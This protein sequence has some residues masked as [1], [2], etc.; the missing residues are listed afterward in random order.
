MS[1][2]RR[3]RDAEYK[4]CEVLERAGY[5]VAR[6]AGSHSPFDVVAVSPTGVRLI[7]V[8][9]TQDGISPGKLE[10]AR[11]QLRM[12]RAPSNVSREIWVWR[13]GDGWVKQEVL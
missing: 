10:V 5:V 3:G 11:E 9:R 6:T 12:I 7:Q 1:N 13:K 2:Y 4:A 8:K